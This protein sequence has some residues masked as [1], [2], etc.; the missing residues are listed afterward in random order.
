M[1]DE[2]LILVVDDDPGL[3][4]QY[5][6]YLE[7]MEMA[8]EAFA[9]IGN[10]IDRINEGGITEV[11]TDGLEGGWREVVKAAQQRGI[12]DIKL[13]TGTK[14]YEDEATDMG[15]GFV[16]KG[17]ALFSATQIFSEKQEGLT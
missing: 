6:F 7:M 1:T 3:L 12:E 16:D 11:V 15:I 13:V 17:G 10:A 5:I 8:F 4:A 14:S 2:R 9:E